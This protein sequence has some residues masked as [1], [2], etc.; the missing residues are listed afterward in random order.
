[1]KLHDYKT[2]TTSIIADLE[3]GVVPWTKPWTDLGVG[4]L[5]YNAKTGHHYSGINILICWAACHKNGFSSPGWM[6]YKQAKDA[7]GYVRKGE[8][9]TRIYYA[10][11]FTKRNEQDEEETVWYLKPVSVFNISQI[12]SL[13]P[14]YYA[15]PEGLPEAVRNQNTEDFINAI[16]STVQYGGNKACYIP[17]RDVIRMPRIEQFANVD[18]YY[19]TLIHEHIHWTSSKD[20]L[21]RDEEYAFEELVA[22][23]GAAFVCAELGIKGNLQHSEYIGSWIKALNNDHTMIVKASRLAS[24]A[25]NYL[26]EHQQ[27]SR[28]A[29]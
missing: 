13:P 22:E 27:V 10:N 20:R 23:L 21:D 7:G 28:K 5:P 18:A 3:A 19:A 29:A 8:R 1:M 14:S 25:A 4:A 2:I 15:E 16:P 6:T 26:I 12:D 24:Q 9:S 11:S 17:S